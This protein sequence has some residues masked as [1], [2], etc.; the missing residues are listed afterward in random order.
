MSFWKKLFGK[1]EQ[2]VADENIVADY[3]TEDSEI[4]ADAQGEPDDQLDVV[5]EEAEIE[6]S[7]ADEVAA[8]MPYLSRQID[9]IRPDIIVA[10]GETAAVSL[11]GLPADTALASL[12]DK[13]HLHADLPLIV[14]YH[15]THLLRQ[16]AD[17]AKSWRDLCGAMSFLDG[18]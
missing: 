16:P 11:L 5:A 3:E 18:R 4:E 10:L 12:R 1:S 17:K 9:L 7:T 13:L 2:P 8:C 6:S 15:P 14:T